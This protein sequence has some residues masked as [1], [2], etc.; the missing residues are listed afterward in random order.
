MKTTLNAIRE[1][2]PCCEGWEKLL[3]TLGKT[4][5]DDEPV[6]IIQVL[7]SN[8]L[9]DA[10][11]CLRAVKGRDKEIRL[12]AV[13]CARQ[14]QHLMTDKRSTDALDVAERFANGE[15]TEQERAAA[16]AAA[17]DAA[18]AAARDAA[19][20]AAGAAARAAAGAAAGDAARAAAGDAARAAA[21]DAARAAAGDAAGAAAG[22]A[23]GDAARDAAGA[24]QEKRLREL[25][26]KCEEVAA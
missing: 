25:C 1:H 19:G 14:V 3:R 26:A 23:A 9:D 11:W 4:K 24:A 12:Y 17:R 6:S 13:W 21:R 18:G 16:R 22:A 20:A 7:D 10:L 2:S 15:A 8:G 5:A